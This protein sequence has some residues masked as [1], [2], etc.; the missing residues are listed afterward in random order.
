MNKF[1]LKKNA[2][3]LNNINIDKDFNLI[4]SDA[5]NALFNIDSDSFD[6]AV[7]SPPYY[8]ARD[9]SLW[10]NIFCYLYDMY[11]IADQSFRTLKDGSVFYII[12]L[13]ILIMKTILFF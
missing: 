11:N 10:D 7:T 5:F 8:N 3:K 9:Y 4:N 13:I 12:Y 1:L 2:T 6:G